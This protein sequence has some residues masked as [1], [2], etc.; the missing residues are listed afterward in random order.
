M[1]PRGIRGGVVVLLVFD[2]LGNAVPHN[3]FFIV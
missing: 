2:M 1:F 3:V